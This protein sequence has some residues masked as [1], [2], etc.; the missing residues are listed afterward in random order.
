MMGKCFCKNIN[1]ISIFEDPEK[2][3]CRDCDQ[4]ITWEAE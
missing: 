3:K 2:G 4:Y 1:W